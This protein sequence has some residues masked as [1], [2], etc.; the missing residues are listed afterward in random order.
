MQRA[1]TNTLEIGPLSAAISCEKA[2][3]KGFLGCLE[4]RVVIGRIFR[5][6]DSVGSRGEI[7]FSIL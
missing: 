2:E 3:G 5:F 1:W 6:V 7:G 4:S